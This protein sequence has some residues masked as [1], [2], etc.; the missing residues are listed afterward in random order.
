MGLLD[1]IDAG[2]AALASWLRL[3]AGASVVDLGQRPERV[4]ELYEFEACPFCKRVREALSMLDLEVLVRPCPKG[5]ERFRPWVVSTGGRAQFP[6]LVDPNDPD[7]RDG[8]Y[9][10]GDILRHLFER[11]GSGEVPLALRLPLVPLLTT[12]LGSALRPLRGAFRR[13]SI[14]PEQPLELYGHEASPGTRRVRETLCE[15]EL[16]YRLRNAARGSQRRAELQSRAGDL[17]IP[18]LID[19][20]TGAQL[21]NPT[22]ICRYLTDTYSGT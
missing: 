22:T 7:T 10:S 6:F 17:H 21:T 3:G 2:T 8:F 14:A 9:E 13:E 5:G 16:P 12:Q 20:N 4:L 19:A 1:A 11:Y 18:F 15:L